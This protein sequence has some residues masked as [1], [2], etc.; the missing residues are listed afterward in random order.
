MKQPVPITPEILTDLSGSAF[1]IYAILTSNADAEGLVEFSLDEIAEKTG[2]TERTVRTARA[3][4]FEKKLTIWGQNTCPSRTR[5]AL[6]KR[7]LCPG[8]NDMTE[9]KWVRFDLAEKQNPKT[10]VWNVVAKGEAKKGGIVLGQ[11]KWF[12]R[13]RKYSF[14]PFCDTIYESDC[15]QNITD[16]LIHENEARLWQSK[17]R[18][19]CGLQG[20]NP[21]LGDRCPACDLE[22]KRQEERGKK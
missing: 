5:R 1:K 20:Y 19:L 15:L 11:I 12:G 22:E 21:G 13:W 18:H 7:M 3:E 8:G 16:F 14:F 2:L 17:P 9:G 4:L 6:H 10:S